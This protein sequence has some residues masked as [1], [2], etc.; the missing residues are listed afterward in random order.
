MLDKLQSFFCSHACLQCWCGNL[1]RSASAAA[2]FACRWTL[3][4][5]LT[6]WFNAYCLVRTY[7]NSFETVCT[8]V[9]VYYWLS[10]PGPHLHGPLSAVNAKAPQSAHLEM[11]RPT[12]SAENAAPESEEDAIKAH[13]PHGDKVAWKTQ[14]A[15]QTATHAKHAQQAGAETQHAQQAGAETQ[16]TQ[17]AGA[18]TQ[19]A[20]QP[21][22]GTQH[23][24]EAQLAIEQPAKV[25]ST[26]Q[27]TH[28]IPGQG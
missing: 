15:Q 26:T 16:H 9:G 6:S 10:S 5:Q 20:Q 1:L 2:C 18:E 8:V 25:N 4:C 11:C 3:V 12:Q 19:H 28:K 17:Q 7:S 13:L 14:L 24:Q 23:A 21:K 22:M 27:H